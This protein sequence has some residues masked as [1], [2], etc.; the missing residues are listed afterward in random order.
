PEPTLAATAG[1]GLVLV[2]TCF[3]FITRPSLTFAIVPVLTIFGLLGSLLDFRVIIAFLIFLLISVFLL[4]YEHILTL[5]EEFGL[6]LSQADTRRLPGQQMR[7][8]GGFLL[9]V[10]ILGLILGSI[11]TAVFS[12]TSV[13][14]LLDALE[15]LERIAPDVRTSGRSPMPSR[16]F[17]GPRREFLVG[18]GPTTLSEAEV[19]Y[20]RADSPA[21]W[22]E[23]VYDLYT[24]NGWRV[25]PGPAS[26]QQRLRR[27]KAVLSDSPD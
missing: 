3:F 22:R 2:V 5:K 9:V 8:S 1:M 6:R 13:Q 19:M 14:G 18:R 23:R 20:V 24:G 25:A 15:G 10:L 4:G 12:H 17:A 11:F 27:G 26:T 21:F 7:I 16:G